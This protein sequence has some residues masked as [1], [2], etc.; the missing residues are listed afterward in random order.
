MRLT[1]QRPWGQNLSKYASILNKY[2]FRVEQDVYENIGSVEIKTLEELHR[3]S[4]D[5]KC[6]LIMFGEY[7]DILI[8]DD[9]IE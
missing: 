1:I 9:Y 7:Q 5:L 6:E 4:L 8:Y 3:L 2:D